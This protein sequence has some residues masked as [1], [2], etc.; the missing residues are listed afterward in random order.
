MLSVGAGFVAFVPTGRAINPIT[1][2]NWEGVGVKPDVALA[3]PQA[4]QAAHL[5]ALRARLKEEQDPERRGILERAITKVETGE[6]AT[7][8]GHP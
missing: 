7:S 4:L 3:A 6:P 8:A 1:R 5:M 2:T